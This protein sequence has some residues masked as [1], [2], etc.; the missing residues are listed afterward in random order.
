M[1]INLEN[2]VRENVKKMAPY[3]SARDEFTGRAEIYLDANENPFENHAYARY[4]DPYQHALKSRLSN[5]K[6][7]AVE[8]IFIGNGS[9][10]IIDLVIRAFCRPGIDNIVSINPSYG[11]YKVSASVNDVG[12]KLVDLDQYFQLDFDLLLEKVDENTKVVFLCSPNNPSG[13]CLPLDEM[14]KF[15]NTFNGIVV[16]DEAYIDFCNQ[17]SM[18]SFINDCNNLLVMQTMS[19]AFA[20][21]ALRLGIGFGHIDLLKI[22]GKIKPPYNISEVAQAEGLKMLDKIEQINQD[23]E[24]V[25]AER[26]RMAVELTAYKEVLQVYP[27]EANFI[28]VKVTD[29]NALYNHCTAKSIVLR[30]RHGQKNCDNCVR[31]TI[32]T[33]EE[34]Q[35]LLQTLNEY[36]HA[37]DIVLG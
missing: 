34:N 16:I 1:I 13:N 8:N 33:R 12:L 32:G 25:K 6:N 24:T 21:A 22:L 4:P 2:L 15:V 19:K 37:E 18:K 11:M 9:D 7:V 23:V 27:S 29:A 10:E 5:V 26:D 14:I 35:K 3:S 30:N 31:I 17:A 20:S 36:Y 28:L